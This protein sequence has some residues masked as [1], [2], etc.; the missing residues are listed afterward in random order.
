MIAPQGRKRTE[1]GGLRR[2]DVRHW[3]MRSLVA[4]PMLGLSVGLALS[5][6]GHPQSA[7]FAW[8]FATIPV[9]VKL[10]ADILSGIARREFGL[11]IVAALSMS[12]ALIFGQELAA[13][14]VALM[15]A[16]GQY[17]EAF[18][19]RRARRDMT[20]LLARAPRR[21]LRYE[22]DRLCEVDA[23]AILPGDRL[24]I[25]RGDVTPADGTVADGSAL[26]DLSALTGESLPVRY[27]PG[28]EIES[29]AT[30]IGNAFDLR[31]SRSAGDSTY[32]AIVRLVEAAQRSKAPMARLADR[33]ALAFLAATVALATLAWL[34]THDTTRVVAV[35]VVATPCPLLLAVPVALVAG[36]SRAARHG[37]LVKSGQALENL[38]RIRVII[39]D[40]TGTLTD[41]RASIVRIEPEVGFDE[42]TILQQAASLDQVSQ[43]V[44]ARTL[45]KAV[46]ERGLALTMPATTAE[47]PGE[48]VTG[49]LE[50]RSIVVGSAAFVSSALR[51]EGDGSQ[52]ISLAPGEIAVALAIDGRLAGR[53]ILS[54]RLR[55]GTEALLASLRQHGI[56][57]IVLATGDQ[58]AIANATAAGLDIDAVH[59]ELAP[60]DKVAIVAAERRFGPVMMI[61][62]G[63]NDAPALA[64]ADIGVAMGARGSAAAAE[65]GDIVLL[66]DRLDRIAKALAVGASARRVALESVFAGIGLSLAGMV[67]AAFGYLSPVQGALLQEL[68]DVAV[69]LNA[70]RVLQD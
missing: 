8:L 57:R 44:I 22:A 20:A 5:A 45:V 34:L 27:R 12:A 21:V 70:L 67:A 29:G 4:I 65:S 52:A 59:A 3:L 51:S 58:A 35:L 43:H 54:D 7:V 48:G 36:M 39:L 50:G 13:A 30:N 56:L 41:G 32:A 61:G 1:G 6:A 60:N 64:A 38:A 19:E 46:D 68:I 17:L 25:R 63:V 37:V 62:D 40:K 31:A 2:F 18:A 9:L 24:L 28:A 49:T 11:D 66:V 69:I 47:T 15:Y 23:D 10:F 33:Y 53:I 16:G 42:D 55:D 14:I 26:L